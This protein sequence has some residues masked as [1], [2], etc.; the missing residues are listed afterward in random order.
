MR[1]AVVSD[2]HGGF[3]HVESYL[4]QLHDVDLLLHLGDHASDGLKIAQRLGIP[5]RAVR[6]NNDYFDDFAPYE[7]TVDCE[8]VRIFMSHG[9]KQRVYSGVTVMYYLAAQAGAQIALFGHTHM[10]F[11]ETFDG[12]RIINPGS[13]SLPRDPSAKKSMVILD[14]ADGDYTVEW[15]TL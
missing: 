2:T 8:G 5:L 9:N 13:A 6:G 14:I 1:V 7:D 3:D 11:D 10:R 4:K 15:V 12:I